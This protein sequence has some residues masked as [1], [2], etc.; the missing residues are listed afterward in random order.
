[1]VKP[2][3]CTCH[4]CR[5]ISRRRSR[6]LAKTITILILFLALARV[7]ISAAWNAVREEQIYRSIHRVYK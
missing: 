5:E 3:D 1:M 7:G 6:N 4:E 2:V